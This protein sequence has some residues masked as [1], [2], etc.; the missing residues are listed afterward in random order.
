MFIQKLKRNY[1][2]EIAYN[3]SIN[4][5]H[6]MKMLKSS[7]DFI[8]DQFW[9]NIYQRS[10]FSFNHFINRCMINRSQLNSYFILIQQL[11]CYNFIFEIFVHYDRLETFKATYNVLLQKLRNSF[12]S[13]IKQDTSFY[14]FS[15]VIFYH[16]EC[17]HQFRLKQINTVNIH[18]LKQIRNSNEMK[19]F[20]FLIESTQLTWLTINDVLF[21]ILIK[22][23]LSIFICHTSIDFFSFAMFILVMKLFQYDC[24]ILCL[25]NDFS[26][27][28]ILVDSFKQM[29]IANKKLQSSIFEFT[30]FFSI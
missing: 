1:I 16:N 17:V 25:I 19:R 29:F 24:L 11:F 12:H 4:S 7:F 10:M 23:L 30:K 3:N 21:T 13:W 6:R 26:W 2:N 18:F 15:Q 8:F 5:Q 22:I 9:Q 28:N 27:Q 20:F 14:S